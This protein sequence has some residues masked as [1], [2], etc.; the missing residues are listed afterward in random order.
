MVSKLAKKTLTIQPSPS[1]DVVGYK[2]YY[3]PA[4]QTLNF[5]S[6]SVDVGMNLSII[7]PDQLPGFETLE[8]D[9]NI[10][11]SAY[12]DWGNETMTDPVIYPLDFIAPLAPVGFTLE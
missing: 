11:V 1:P 4:S 5:N 10:A 6:D 9:Y 8:G 7:V 3:C 2:V 12:D